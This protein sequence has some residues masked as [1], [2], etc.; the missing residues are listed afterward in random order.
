MLSSSVCFASGK[1]AGVL[2]ELR[3]DALQWRFERV[4]DV[5]QGGLSHSRIIP[6]S[7]PSESAFH[8]CSD[9]VS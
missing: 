2:P 7:I 3:T 4:Y 6:K 9:P 1:G 5:G 8:P